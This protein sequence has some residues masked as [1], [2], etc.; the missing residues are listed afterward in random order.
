MNPAKS[1][2]LEVRR[3]T[4]LTALLLLLPLNTIAQDSR[5]PGKADPQ[6]SESHSPQPPKDS[7]VNFSC[8]REG[9]ATAGQPTTEGLEWVAKQGYKAVINFRTDNEG[10][11]IKAE[12]EIA[13]RLGM[14]YVHIPVSL[15]TL[16]DDQ[17]EAFMA[18]MKHP[19]NHPIFIH[20]GSANRVGG[21][22]MIYLVEKDGY[23]MEKAEEEARKVGLSSPKLIEFARDYLKRHPPQEKTG[24]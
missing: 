16:S 23:S 14:N 11:D 7:I 5:T 22:W 3:L 8:P 18:A 20:C 9:V 2:L 12:T 24:K 6:A 19:Q 1:S 21:F 4:F 13:K 10:V 15:S 17:V